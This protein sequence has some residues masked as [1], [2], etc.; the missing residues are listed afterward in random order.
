MLRPKTETITSYNAESGNAM[1][2]T[3][4]Q[5]TYTNKLLQSTAYTNSDGQRKQTV[6]HYPFDYANTSSIYAE[7]REK[8]L[9]SYV[10][11][12][13]EITGSGTDARVVDVVRAH[14]NK[15][16]AGFFKPERVDWSF[17]ETMDLDTYNEQGS[18]AVL[19]PFVYYQYDDQGNIAEILSAA[20][21]GENT[22]SPAEALPAGEGTATV[23]L[24][25]Y[26]GQYL[27]AKIT[28]C[29]YQ[30]ICN[31]IGNGNVESGINA[32]KTMSRRES[33]YRGR[34]D[35]HQQFEADVASLTRYFLYL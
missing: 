2:T 23:Y 24:W 3:T 8:H 26:C 9:F 32:L 18:A 33:T 17:A 5:Y 31:I 14:Y 20:C 6:Y 30:T 16:P 7:M 10:V 28:N 27:I 13:A 11:E 29:T 19:K 21:Y 34:M 35:I 1:Q 4:M 25:G 12:K 22:N 15:T